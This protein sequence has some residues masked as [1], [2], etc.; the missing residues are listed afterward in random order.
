[1]FREDGYRPSDVRGFLHKSKFGKFVTGAVKTLVPAIGVATE[2][3]G[4]AKSIFRPARA[5]VP[6]TST[7]RPTIR[8]EQ[9][10]NFGRELKF[11]AEPRL[12][13]STV[14]P[15]QP[16]D[17]APRRKGLRRGLAGGNGCP[18]PLILSPQGNC[19]APTSPRGAELFMGEATM[20]RY[21]AAEIPGTQ[22]IDRAVCRAGT[23]L[24]DDGLCYGKGT[25]TNSQ[26]MW[27]RGRR[28]LLTGGDMRAISIAARA[29]SKLERTTKRLRSLGMMKALPRRG[30]PKAHAHAKPVA[31][32]SVSS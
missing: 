2:V 32:V 28:P 8:G 10:K 21:G 12:T 24:G 1:M 7:A 11:A 16:F 18:E 30:T 23:T 22:I 15:L 5:T 26:R 19:I 17:A 29:G 6:R 9:G 4:V 3:A 31:A 27:P 14:Q 13:V 20:G 25:I